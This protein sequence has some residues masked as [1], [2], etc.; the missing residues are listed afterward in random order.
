MANEN[1]NFQVS[2]FE[3]EIFKRFPTIFLSFSPSIPFIIITRWRFLSENFLHVNFLCDSFEDSPTAWTAKDRNGLAAFIAKFGIELLL[4][5]GRKINFV[6]FEVE[7]AVLFSFGH[8]VATNA[9][10]TK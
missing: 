9:L 7:L 1:E 3:R 10:S 6:E 5:G 2:D 8:E 4:V